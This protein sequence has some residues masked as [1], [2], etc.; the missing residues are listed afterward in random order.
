MTHC[1]NS[2]YSTVNNKNLI[3]NKKYYLANNRHLALDSTRIKC[4]KEKF[5]GYGID[6]FLNFIEYFHVQFGGDILPEIITINTGK[7]L[8]KNEFHY[9]DKRYVHKFIFNDSGDKIIYLEY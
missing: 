1:L 4:K 3:K 2:F 8:I 5:T 9:K 7:S 6:S